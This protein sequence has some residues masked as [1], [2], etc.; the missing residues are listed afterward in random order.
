MIENLTDA[1]EKY[2]D[3]IDSENATARALRAN[4]DNSAR[5]YEETAENDKKIVEWL[6][7]LQE[8]R[9]ADKWISVKDRMP[10]PRV[11]VMVY[12]PEY[13]NQYCAFYED[14]HWQ[15]FGAYD[16]VWNEVTH[17]KPLSQDPEESEVENG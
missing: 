1:I 3:F 12:C 6:T 13:K 2:N 11:A 8:R 4:N 15:V 17:W 16:T 7:E 9:E 10:E 5:F 14:K